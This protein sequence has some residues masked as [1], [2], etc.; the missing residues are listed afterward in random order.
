MD[1]PNQ[2]NV[3]YP[4]IEDFVSA[5]L[6]GRAPLVTAGEAFKTTKVVDAIYES[7]AKNKEILL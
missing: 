5:V 7:A 2:D 4:L 6:E 1:L 3:H